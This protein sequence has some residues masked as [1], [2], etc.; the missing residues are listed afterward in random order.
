MA[1]LEERLFCSQDVGSSNLLGGTNN[2]SI[3][4]YD[5][6][7]EEVALLKIR[8]KTAR[9]KEILLL[10]KLIEVEQ[11][12]A[13]VNQREVGLITDQAIARET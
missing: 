12:L 11:R 3:S 8:L 6:L 1:Q 10:T 9:D 5:K 7:R 2:M 13:Q 4:K